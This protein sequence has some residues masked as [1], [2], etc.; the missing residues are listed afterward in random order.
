[1]KNFASYILTYYCENRKVEIKSTP[2]PRQIKR[3]QIGES[4]TA[5]IKKR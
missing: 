5:T 1:M 2:A 3:K 4:K